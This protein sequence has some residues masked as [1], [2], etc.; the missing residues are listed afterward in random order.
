MKINYD[1]KVDILYIKLKETEYYESDEIKEGII[2]DYDK[3]GNI[4][5]IEILDASN[6]MP[7]HELST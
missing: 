2:L 3:N 7:L 6:Y 4:I 1:E 5:S